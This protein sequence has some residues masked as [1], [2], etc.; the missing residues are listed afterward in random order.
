MIFFPK[1][2]L[3]HPAA[4]V[5]DQAVQKELAP[6]I[7]VGTGGILPVQPDAVKLLRAPDKALQPLSPLLKFILTGTPKEAGT[8]VQ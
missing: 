3:Q 2:I 7:I 8:A 4:D 6:V 1:H 5:R